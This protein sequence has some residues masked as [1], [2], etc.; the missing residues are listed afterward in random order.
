MPGRRQFLQSS[1][2]GGISLLTVSRR[3][4]LQAEVQVASSAE[5]TSPGYQLTR[6]VPTKLYDGKRCW[7]HPRAGIVPGAGKSGQPRV[8]MTMNTL[9]LSGSDVFKA[10]HGLSTDD[11]GQSWTEPAEL[12][13]LA[14][15]YETIEGVRRPVAVSDFWPTWHR[16]SKSL[17]GTGHTVVYTPDWKVRNPRPRHTSYSVYQPE[18]DTWRN[19]QKL[20]MP[21]GERFQD[22]G[23]GCVQRWDLDDG[24]I[25]LPI[26]FRAPGRN[27]QVI[28]SRCGFDGQTLKLL[29]YG[30]VQSIDDKTRGLHEPS[31]VEFGGEY[32]QTM[33]NDRNAFVARSSDGL[34]FSA[35]QPWQFDDGTP[36]GSYNTQ[37]HWVRHSEGLFLVYTRRGAKNDHVFRHRAPLFMAQVDPKSLRVIRSTE[38]I[39]VPERGARLGNFG[40]TTV[41]PEETW[42][43]VSE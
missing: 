9:H 25:L 41:S 21:E 15:Q 24:S 23:A 2:V 34:E 35:Y 33:R 11:L 36:L 22:A 7:C 12:D 39:L 6:D 32:F 30:N 10:M 8:V 20:P 27:S 40:V 14:I 18:T 38:Q 5:S 26:Y 1:L 19:W 28:V 4:P 42:V 16:A 13:S 17:L 31:I 3:W 29:E 43:T 37:A